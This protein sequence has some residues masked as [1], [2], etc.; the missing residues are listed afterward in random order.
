MGEPEGLFNVCVAGIIEHNAS[1]EILIIKRSADSTSPLDW[2]ICCG[3]LPQSEE[4]ISG[5]KREA[6]EETGLKVEVGEPI[7]V[8]HFFRGKK[9]KENEWVGITFACRTNSRKVKL[10]SEHIDSRWVSAK[11]A[12]KLIAH[13]G[14]KQDIRAFL[15]YKANTTQK[16]FK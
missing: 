3:I 10:S 8:F 14:I 13:K 15:R 16:Q 7:R 12:L 5:L 9:K 6:R 1:G 2:D 4:P 11:E